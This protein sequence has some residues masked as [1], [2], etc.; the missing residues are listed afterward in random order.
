MPKPNANM[1]LAEMRSYVRT[2]KLNH[3][4]VK[5]GMKRSQLIAGL[6]K[7][8]HWKE[9]P[10]KKVS[11]AR[12]AL[13]RGTTVPKGATKAQSDQARKN[14]AGML[15]KPKPSGARL[16]KPTLIST[17]P[18][19]KEYVKQRGLQAQGIKL[20]VS[21]EEMRTQLK[22]KGH[23]DYKFDT[24]GKP[25]IMPRDAVSQLRDF[26]RRHG[27][28]REAQRVLEQEVIR[29]GGGGGSIEL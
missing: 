9:V 5:L 17:M 27:G 22:D 2:H 3:P 6:K 21:K 10:P 8:G 7:A 12:A 16:G 26:R 20:N 15:G 11:E 13:K 25:T 18:Q 4:E 29:R 24:H 14:L 1:T 19:M 23:W 28:G